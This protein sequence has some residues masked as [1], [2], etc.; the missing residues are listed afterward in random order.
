MNLKD[1][2]FLREEVKPAIRVEI[3]AIKAA[4]RMK[5]KGAVRLLDADA[6]ERQLADLEKRMRVAETN[7]DNIRLRLATP[8]T[9]TA[10]E[11]QAE[12]PQVEEEVP[13]T[14][15]EVEQAEKDQQV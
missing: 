7:I 15:Q 8:T 12:K 5:R 13:P 4:L 1:Q 6:V 11:V 9:K 14:R 2:Q 3:P 10:E